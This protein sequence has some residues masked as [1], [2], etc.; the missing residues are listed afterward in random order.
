MEV[1][2]NICIGFNIFYQKVWNGVLRQMVSFNM[3]K[4]LNSLV[5]L[6]SAKPE[7]L[8]SDGLVKAWECVLKLPFKKANHARTFDQE[9][10]LTKA[11]FRIQSCPLAK[12]LDLLEIAEDCIR[13]ERPHM[14]VA[15]VSFTEADEQKSKIRKMLKPYISEE[16]RTEVLALEDSGILSVVLNYSLKEIG[17]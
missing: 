2:A 13:L 15:L 12:K 7:L 6:L 11:L 3:T 1:I 4:E 5:E 16:L 14:A 10:I 9:E 8:H 17:L